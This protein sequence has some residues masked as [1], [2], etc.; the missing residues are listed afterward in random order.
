MGAPE[1]IFDVAIVGTG[2]AGATFARLLSPKLRV[3]AFDKKCATDPLARGF[4]KPCGGLLAEDA[5]R[6]L[7]RQGLALPKEVLAN[8]QLF[9]VRTIDLARNIERTYRRFYV[10]MDRHRFDLWLKS[11]IP[12]SVEIH[13]ATTAR[14]ISRNKSGLWEIRFFEER[15]EKIVVARTLVGADGAASVVRKFLFPKHKIRCYTAIQQWFVDK[16]PEPIYACFFDERLT[17]CYGWAVSKDGELLFGAAFP[18]GGTGGAYE[19]LRRRAEKFGFVLDAPL[20]SEACMVLRPEKMGDFKIG[21][22]EG[23]FLIGEAAGFISPSSL[24]GISYALD[25]AEMLA[26]AFNENFP[27]LGGGDNGGGRQGVAEKIFEAY[28]R[29]SRKICRKLLL[30]TL[31]NP[32]MYNPTLREIVMK[33]GISA[34]RLR[35]RDKHSREI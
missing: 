19:N 6:A 25:S 11:L 5:Q 33:S 17:D 15:R 23:A 24:E 27:R 3:V 14:K 22:V 2:P 28:R 16:Q 26:D 12:P 9:S 1:E 35:P 13:N 30:K 8:P 21:T 10:N 29:R 4:R 18:H 20:R 31:K 34:L 7:S 32:F